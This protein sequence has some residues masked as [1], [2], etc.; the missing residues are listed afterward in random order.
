MFVDGRRADPKTIGDLT[1]VGTCG[2]KID[3]LLFACREDRG[4]VR[5]RGHAASPH[6]T[7]ELG[8][9]RSR[10]GDLSIQD[11]P[12]R[13]LERARAYVARDESVKPDPP[14]R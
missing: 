7:D 13:A 12:D 6:Q 11:R 1:V 3:H 5:D 4:L 8:A 2:N 10:K 14:K 9:R